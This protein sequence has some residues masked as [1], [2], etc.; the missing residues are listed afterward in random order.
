MINGPD[1]CELNKMD[2]LI[3]ALGLEVAIREG[4]MIEEEVEDEDEDEE[5]C[6][7]QI[8]EGMHEEEEELSDRGAP[9]SMQSS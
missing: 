7:E 4:M 9:S 6:H 5:D 8:N 3:I 1:H 2:T